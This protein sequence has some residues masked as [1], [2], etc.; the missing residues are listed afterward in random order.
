LIAQGSSKEPKSDPCPVLGVGIGR[1]GGSGSGGISHR[2]CSD[3]EGLRFAQCRAEIV[4]SLSTGWL[5]QAAPIHDLCVR[6][7]KDNGGSQASAQ[8]S[9]EQASSTTSDNLSKIDLAGGG[10][11]PRCERK[12][13]EWS[14]ATTT[15]TSS[16]SRVQR[17]NWE[18]P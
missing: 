6:D 7:L 18:A 12:P 10:A 2:Q 16:P 9:M 14:R 13:E 5:R 1:L 15:T 8:E 17:V 3:R 11:A 4:T